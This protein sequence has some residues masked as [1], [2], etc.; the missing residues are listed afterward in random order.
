[1]DDQHLKQM[2]DMMKS[3]KQYMKEMYK[4][5]GMEISEEMLDNIQSMMTPDTLKQTS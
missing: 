3:N 2:V 4:A 1:M 5:Q